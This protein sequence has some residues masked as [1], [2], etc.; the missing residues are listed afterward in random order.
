[1]VLTD[2]DAVGVELKAYDWIAV[3]FCDVCDVCDD[4]AI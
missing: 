1:M 3:L 4:C 2:V